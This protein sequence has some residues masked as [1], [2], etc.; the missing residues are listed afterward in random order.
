MTGN[1]LLKKLLKTFLWLA[2]A[3]LGAAALGK[4]ALQRGE[5]LNAIWFVIAAACCYL[6][7]FRIYSAFIAA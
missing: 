1:G 6:V 3:I 7:A 4:I 2:I 5:T